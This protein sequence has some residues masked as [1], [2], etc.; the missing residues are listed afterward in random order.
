[1]TRVF[2][3]SRHTM[4][5]RGLE[6]LLCNKTGVTIVGQA[7]SIA[8]AIEQIKQLQP[9]IVILDEYKLAHQ[10]GINK[11]VSLLNAGPGIRVVGLNL[12]SNKIRVYQATDWDATNVEDLVDAIEKPLSLLFAPPSATD[13]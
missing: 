3:I 11:I 6:S 13:R 8:A 1:M 5:A 9:H 12:Q 4:F 10:D 2:I 7:E